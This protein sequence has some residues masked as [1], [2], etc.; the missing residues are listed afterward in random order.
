VGHLLDARATDPQLTQDDHEHEELG[1]RWL[2]EH[3]GPEVTRPIRL[4]VAAK[5]YLCATDPAYLA[6]LSPSSAASLRL[7]GGPMTPAEVAEFE[8]DP[9]H[10]AAVRLRRWDDEAKVAGLATPPLE[11]FQRHLAVAQRL[12]GG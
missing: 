3:F 5:R 12:A 7:Q 4:H 6:R 11:H 8:R 1:A 10:G 9:F 2:E